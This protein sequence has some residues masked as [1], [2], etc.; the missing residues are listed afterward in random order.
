MRPATLDELATAAGIDVPPTRGFT[1]FAAFAGMYDAACRVVAGETQMRRLVREVVEDAHRDGVTWLEPSFYPR[2]YAAAYGG[3]EAVLAVVLDELAEAGDALGVGSG[4]I[5]TANRSADPDEARDLARVAV[6]FRD[7]GVV[8]FGLAHDEVAGPAGRFADAFRIATDGGLLAVPHGGELVGP[9]SVVSCLDD[10]GAHRVMHGVR[11]AEDPDLVV[12]LADSEVCLDVC[13]SSNLALA[14][15]DSLADHPLPALLDAGVDCSINADD[16]LLFGPGILE[17]YELCR[18]TMGLDDGALAG[19]ARTS[20]RAS[21]APEPVVSS[22][23]RAI[24]AW[25]A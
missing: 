1:S 17:E 24:D 7:R 2:R 20:L 21:A 13:P 22:G 4:L 16:P 3:V 5:V 25:L 14:V 19:V 15:V 6:A 12:R 11:A 9:E 18:S 10:C 8:A 23:L